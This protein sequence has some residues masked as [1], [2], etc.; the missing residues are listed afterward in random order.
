M[1]APQSARIT[2]SSG[3]RRACAVAKDGSHAN[4]K[5]V[6]GK[7]TKGQKSRPRI[8]TTG[9]RFRMRTRRGDQTEEP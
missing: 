1:S 4:R 6:N 2:L 8:T 5:V 3:A 7:T 9:K